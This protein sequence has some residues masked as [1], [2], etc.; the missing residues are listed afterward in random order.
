[1]SDV[2][3]AIQTVQATVVGNMGAPLRT[4]DTSDLEDEE[5]Y[6]SKD[7]FKFGLVLEESEQGSEDD[8]GLDV[9][10]R[11]RVHVDE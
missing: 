1:M 10:E 8:V 5:L 2:G 3:F 6:F 4:G 7:P 9:V 11:G